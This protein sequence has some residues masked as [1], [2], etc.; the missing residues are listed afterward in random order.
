MRKSSFPKQLTIELHPVQ[1][2]ELE[3]IA[4]RLSFRDESDLLAYVI[5]TGIMSIL[6]GYMEPLASQASFPLD[7]PGKR[8]R[9]R[10]KQ[11]LEEIKRDDPSLADMALA[12]ADGSDPPRTEGYVGAPLDAE[13]QERFEAWLEERPGIGVEEALTTLLRKALDAE[14][15]LQDDTPRRKAVIRA[16]RRVR[17]A[18]QLLRRAKQRCRQ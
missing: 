2:R 15:A 11:M 3:Q 18:E 9:D 16:A 12:D 14:E 10:R 1:Q 17:F 4:K 8:Y 7:P 5:G 6:E 13:L